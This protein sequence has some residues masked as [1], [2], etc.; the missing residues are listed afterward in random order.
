MAPPK[1]S[2]AAPRP[3][4][5][6]AAPVAPAPAPTTVWALGIVPVTRMGQTEHTIV[7][8]EITGD[9]CVAHP[10]PESNYD[11]LESALNDMRSCAVQGFRFRKWDELLAGR[12]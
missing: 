12:V 8:Y 4:E 10:V 2:D 9:R 7:A 6:A 11:R 3:Y 1:K 5:R